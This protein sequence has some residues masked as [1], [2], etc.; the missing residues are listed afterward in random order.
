MKY[1][2]YNLPGG[3]AVKLEAYIDADSNG[4]STQP[5]DWKKIGETTDDGN[6]PAPAGSCGF[7]EDTVVTEGGGV[8]FI[9]NTDV[10]KVEY[11]KLSWREITN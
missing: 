2:A 9:R 7:P 10:G 1:I 4:T 5:G 3:N 6:W 8:V 11:T